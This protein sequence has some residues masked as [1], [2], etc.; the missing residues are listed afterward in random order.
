MEAAQSEAR[1]PEL[2]FLPSENILRLHLTI[3]QARDRYGFVFRPLNRYFKHDGINWNTKLEYVKD[4]EERGGEIYGLY[5]YDAVVDSKILP[6][7]KL[8]ELLIA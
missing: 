6:P 2:A 5:K 1:L 7:E 4:T 3:E 8:E